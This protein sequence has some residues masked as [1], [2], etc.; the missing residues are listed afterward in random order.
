[1]TTKFSAYEEIFEINAMAPAEG[2]EVVEP[3]RE[4]CDRGFALLRP[5]GDVAED[6]RARAE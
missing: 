4:S 3:Q 1:M 5:L 2:G 6:P